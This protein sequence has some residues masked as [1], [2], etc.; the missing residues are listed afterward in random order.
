MPKLLH[1]ADLQA[2]CAHILIACGSSP[3]EAD[4]VAANLVLANL[5]GHDSHGVGMLPRYV[6]AIA[7]GGL[8]PN[9][10]VKVSADIGT[11]MA[12]DGQHGFGQ[13]VGVQAM[14]LGITD[15]T[16]PMQ[17]IPRYQAAI[18]CKR[19]VEAAKK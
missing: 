13:V 11:L 1:A 4:Q 2:H 12:L 14:E 7:E 19:A 6:D 9:T 5:S 17:L 10:A 8:L 15:G 18:M 16:R 3:A